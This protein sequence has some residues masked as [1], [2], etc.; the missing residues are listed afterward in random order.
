MP[1][2]RRQYYVVADIVHLSRRKIGALRRHVGRAGAFFGSVIFLFLLLLAAAPALADCQPASPV[3]GQTVTCSGTDNNGFQAGGG[4]NQLTVN[5]QTG[6]TVNNIGGIAIGVNDLNTVTNNGAV[7]AGDDGT[8][9]SAGNNNIVTNAATG[10]ITLGDAV[11]AN[12]F[13]IVVV[14]NNTVVNLGAIQVGTAGCGCAVGISAGNNNTISNVGPITG[15]DFAYGIQVGDNNTITN[16]GAISVG[17]G[18]VGITAG[19]G[20]T[21]TIHCNGI[22]QFR[23]A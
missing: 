18:G 20:N 1:A 16:S 17:L 8:G 23:D 4:V 22:I 11:N 13:G 6:A 15:G 21:I 19:F 3:S 7:N 5:V 10:T 2:C 12:A 9:I 14:D